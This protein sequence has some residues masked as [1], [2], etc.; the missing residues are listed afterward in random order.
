MTS[1]LN[2]ADTPKHALGP[3]SSVETDIKKDS[4]AEYAHL[5]RGQSLIHSFRAK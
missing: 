2:S 3:T 1:P 5:E 4:S